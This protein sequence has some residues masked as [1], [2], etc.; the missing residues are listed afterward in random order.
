MAGIYIHIPFCKTRCIYCDFF[1]NVRMDKKNRYVEAL[2]D[3]IRRRKPYLKDETVR[4]VYFGGGT[5]SQLDYEDF[6]SI[7]DTLNETFDLSGADEITLE[8][9]PDDLTPEYIAL[10]RK[11][12]FN[13]LSMGIQSFSDKDLKFLNRRH[14]AASAIRAVKACQEAGFDNI[15]IDLMYGLP[16]QTMEGWLYNLKTALALDVQ[17][18]SSYHLIYEEGTRLYKLLEAGKVAEADEDLSLEMFR[19][20]IDNLREGGFIHYEVSNFGREGRFSQHNSSYWRGE[21]YLGLGPAAH[22]YNGETRSWNVADLDKYIA[23]ETEGEEE[24]LTLQERYNDYILTSLRTMWGLPLDV[25]EEQFGLPLYDY[26]MA[27]ALPHLK[28]GMLLK[29]ENRLKLS[30]GGIFVSDGIMSDLMYVD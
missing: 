22:S 13:R 24:T 4:T 20:L 5:P 9:N 30:P 12:P 16:E 25:L 27:Q 10:L 3:E 6:R 2:C 11:L 8:A 19:A 17:H 7:F 15:S 18:I 1:S 14:D 26:C 21:N 28:S 23:G 29:T